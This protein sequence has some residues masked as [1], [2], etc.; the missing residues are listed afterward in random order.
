MPFNLLFLLSRVKGNAL[1]HM[2]SPICLC[3]RSARTVHWL[4]FT[5]SAKFAIVTHNS[6][7]QVKFSVSDD[8]EAKEKWRCLTRPVIRDNM[9]HCAFASFPCRLP[10]V[11]KLYV[12]WWTFASHIHWLGV[13]AVMPAMPS[14]YRRHPLTLQ[15]NI[16]KGNYPQFLDMWSIS[17]AEAGRGTEMSPSLVTHRVKCMLGSCTT[18]T[19]TLIMS[20]SIISL[21]LNASPPVMKGLE[22]VAFR[23][24]LCH[25][26]VTCL[27]G[28]GMR[29]RT[30]CEGGRWPRGRVKLSTFTAWTPVRSWHDFHFWFSSM[31][32]QG[33]NRTTTSC[34]STFHQCKEMHVLNVLQAM[35]NWWIPHLWTHSAAHMREGQSLQFKANV[36]CEYWGSDRH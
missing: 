14:V 4:F 1:T 9:L 34:V 25:W 7:V 29:H 24:V 28:L 11:L 8:G 22:P 23:H 27:M 19:S 10:L 6:I 33:G 35:T 15:I 3:Q 36:A 17:A 16:F 30:P 31:R 2:D 5:L 18:P 26:G 12:A 13:V 20:S 32:R 21:R